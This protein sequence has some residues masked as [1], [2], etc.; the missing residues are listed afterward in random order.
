M[1]TNKVGVI[2]ELRTSLPKTLPGILMF[3]AWEL[4][5]LVLGKNRRHKNIRQTK[6]SPTLTMSNF[7][8]PIFNLVLQL[9]IPRFVLLDRLCHFSVILDV[10][11]EKHLLARNFHHILRRVEFFAEF[12]ER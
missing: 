1:S 9:F 10:F 8:I 6:K 4:S 11:P 12:D 3:P 2:V 7:F 5:P